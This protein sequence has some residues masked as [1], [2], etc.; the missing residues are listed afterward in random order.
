[1]SG[2]PLAPFSAVPMDASGRL[3]PYIYQGAGGNAAPAEEG[4]GVKASLDADSVWSLR[5]QIPPTVPSGSLYLRC[6][7]LASAASGSASWVT[8]D[9]RSPPPDSPSAITL[10][11]E[12]TQTFTWAVGGADKYQS[13]DQALSTAV[14]G[15]DILVVAVTFKTS[16]WTLAAVSAWQFQLIWK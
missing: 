11:T 2:G 12:T 16:G 1:M 7:A 8:S 13:V 14:Q 9:G 3:F 4:L 6:L 5:F 15:E 10:T